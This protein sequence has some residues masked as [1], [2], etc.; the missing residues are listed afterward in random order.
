MTSFMF[1]L[2]R[3][4][5]IHRQSKQ[6]NSSKVHLVHKTNIGFSLHHLKYVWYY[7][8]WKKI[9][10]WNMSNMGPIY[11]RVRSNLSTAR[12]PSL[13]FIAGLNTYNIKATLQYYWPIIGLGGGGSSLHR[14]D[15]QLNTKGG[16][17]KQV[18]QDAILGGLS[19]GQVTRN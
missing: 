7:K 9:K 1:L 3:T 12:P 19:I 13:V 18:R 6:I 15:W 4:T 11:K 2:D 5:T 10:T 16:P 17:T 14:Q 8:G